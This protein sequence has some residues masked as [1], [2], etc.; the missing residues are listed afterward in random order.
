[1]TEHEFIT[2][3][4]RTGDGGQR[5][6]LATERVVYRYRLPITV[7]AEVEMPER[8]DILSLGP[9]RDGRDELDMWALVDPGAPTRLHRFL[10]CGT[11]HPVPV[12]RG[13]FIGSVTTH[14][15]QLVW[16]VWAAS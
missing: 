10:I 14:G 16:H 1:M 5:A 7:V 2:G 4:L 13:P 6:T 12:N 9:P 8:P 3:T 15:G 11:G